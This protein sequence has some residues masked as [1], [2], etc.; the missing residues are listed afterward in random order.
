MNYCLPLVWKNKNAQYL[1]MKKIANTL[2]CMMLPIC[3][4]ICSMN[5]AIAQDPL[6]A[7]TIV[8]GPCYKIIETLIKEHKSDSIAMKAFFRYYYIQK[9]SLPVTERSSTEQI[10]HYFI[11]NP[12]VICML[13][14]D[15]STP[16][17][18]D[19]PLY[20]AVIRQKE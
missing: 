14:E 17:T 19:E 18:R 4:F 15:T 12:N 8:K 3:I 1:V 6:P 11:S 9:Q 20:A 7:P 13:K 5:N 10:K 2:I 16:V